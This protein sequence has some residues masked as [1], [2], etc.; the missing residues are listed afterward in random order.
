MHVLGVEVSVSGL[1]WVGLEGSSS[2]C[3]V[4]PVPQAKIGLPQAVESEI[5]QLLE[6]K[7]NIAS[8]LATLHPDA[9][10]V[11]KATQDCSVPRIK[12]ECMLQLASKEL[13]ISCHLMHPQTISAAQKRH[14]V[15]KADAATYAA[16]TG[17]TP[18]YLRKAALAAWCVLDGKR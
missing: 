11:V 4:R 8:A 17:L 15:S 2:T 13:G 1:V 7:A 5:D 3:M 16:V 10:A 6:F 18:A 9:I 12:N 14:M